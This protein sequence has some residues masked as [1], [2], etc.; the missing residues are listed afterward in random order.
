VVVAHG[1]SVDVTSIPGRTAFT[2]RLPVHN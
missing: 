1:G 2:V